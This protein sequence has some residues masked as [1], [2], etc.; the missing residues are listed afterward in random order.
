[1]LNTHAEKTKRKKE[2]EKFLPCWWL[3]LYDILLC[4]FFCFLPCLWP[5]SPQGPRRQK[6]KRDISGKVFFFSECYA[7]SCPQSVSVTETVNICIF[8]NFTN[9]F[10]FYA[11]DSWVNWWMGSMFVDVTWMRHSRRLG[12]LKIFFKRIEILARNLAKSLKSCKI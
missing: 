2:S 10:M 4:R 11:V 1:M 3:R 9:K 7:F 5:F 6:K 8:L 12:L